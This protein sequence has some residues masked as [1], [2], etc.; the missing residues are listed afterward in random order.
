M[1]RL[2]IEGSILDMARE[3]AGW[4]VN[5]IDL[6]LALPLVASLMCLSLQRLG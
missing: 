5:N 4:L 6:V 2:N 3:L 1:S